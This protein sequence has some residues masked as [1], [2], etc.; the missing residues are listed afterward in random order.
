MD[1]QQQTEYYARH[2]KDM[3]RRVPDKVNNGSYETSVA[4]K[5][6]VAEANKVLAASRPKLDALM[7][8]HRQLS[9]YY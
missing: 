1:T 6:L 9:S 3:L 5:K 2:I 8:V 4:F 7:Q